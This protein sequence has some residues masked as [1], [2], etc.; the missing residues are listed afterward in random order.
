MV[1]SRA[2]TWWEEGPSL[3]LYAGTW[4]YN[5]TQIGITGYIS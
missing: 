5:I 2:G 1:R 4:Y 3:E